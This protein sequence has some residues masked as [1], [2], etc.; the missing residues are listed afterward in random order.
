MTVRSLRAAVVT[1]VASAAVVATSLVSAAS[2][3]ADQ[4]ITTLGPLSGITVTSD[5]NCGVDQVGDQYGEWYGEIA[6]GTF[7]ALGAKVFTPASVPAGY[8]GTPWTPV[9]QSPVTGDGSAGSPYTVTTVVRAGTQGVQVTEVDSYVAGAQ[10][11]RTDVT[12]ANTGTTTRP[13]VL[14][15]AGDCFFSDSDVGYGRV[16]NGTAPACVAPSP[17]DPSVPGPRVET[18][19][20]LTAGSAYD[21][22]YYGSVW[23]VV[24]SRTGFANTCRCTAADGAFDNGMGLS[25]SATLAAGASATFSHLTRF[26]PPP[27]RT[28]LTADAVAVVPGAND[29]F[30]ISVANPTSKPVTVDAFVD[31]LPD[32]FTY[33]PESTTGDLTADPTITGQQLRWPGPRTL[34]PGGTVSWHIGVGVGTDTRVATDTATAQVSTPVDQT[35]LPASVDVEVAPVT[36]TAASPRAVPTGSVVTVALAGTTLTDGG[37]LV[38]SGRGVTVTHLAVASPHELDATLRVAATAPTGQRSL[39]YTDAAGHSATCTRCLLV[40]PAPTVT[41]VAPSALGQGATNVTVLVNGTGFQ[42]G[43]TVDV[44]GASVTR[45]VF[46]SA[47]QLRL[48]VS[49]PPSTAV[50]PE[51]VTVYNPDGGSAA[52]SVTV[53]PAPK[54][55]AANPATLARGTTQD[56]TFTGRNLVAGLT[57]TTTAAGVTV[58]TPTVQ[59]ATSFVVSITVAAGAAVGT[60]TFTV[61]NPDGGRTTSKVL[62]IS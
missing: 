41:S 42:R 13:V 44:A 50:G 45:V 27:L 32:G 51:P 39:T 3:R 15:R 35:A 34:P 52:G 11:Y 62:H 14:S 19:V 12:V 40:N 10:E 57:F 60:P 9:S 20:P 25:W 28:T 48:Q 6:C 4:T 26:S 18:L 7:L 5:L 47:T 54:V 53:T 38:V 43:A 56:V 16:D 29:G 23:S 46:V 59:S 2:A 24:A 21:V 49:V 22:D 61:V 17:D 36:L 33:T 55:T 1:A 8:V 58:G 31:T 37:H 30:A